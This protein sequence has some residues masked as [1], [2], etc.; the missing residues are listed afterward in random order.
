MFPPARLNEDIGATIAQT[1]DILFE[2]VTDLDVQ[3]SS[4]LIEWFGGLL[5]GGFLFDYS[6]YYHHPFIAIVIIMTFE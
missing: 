2:R 1:L 4:Q 6:S 3:S 5:G